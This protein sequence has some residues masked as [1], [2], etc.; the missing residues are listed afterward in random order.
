MLG[1]MDTVP[2][3]RIGELSARELHI[4]ALMA[5]GYSNTGISALLH[6]SSKTVETHV[7]SIYRK[8]DLP[9]SPRM[10][11]RVMSVLLYR[12]SPRHFRRAA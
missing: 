8:L 7:R 3:D 11:R 9:A 2:A 10:H 1:G 4:L 12:A 6:L 5:E